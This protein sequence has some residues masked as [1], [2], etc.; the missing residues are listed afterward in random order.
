MTFPSSMNLF[1]PLGFAVALSIVCSTG[2]PLWA[3]AP[4]TSTEQLGAVSLPVPVLTRDA[5]GLVTI[6]GATA[7]QVVCYTLDGTDPISRSGPYLAPVDLS[8]GGKIKARIF[9]KDRKQSGEIAAESYEPIVGL[10]PISNSLVPVTQDRSW[11]SYDWAKRHAEVSAA[12]QRQHP[13]VI[14]IGDSITHFFGGNAVWKQNYEP[15]N[16]VNLGFGW[17]RTE[18][19]LWRLEHGELDGASPKV[20]VVMIGTNNLEKNKDEEIAD[21]IKAICEEIHRR[22]PTTKILLLGIFPRGQKPGGSRDR[23]AH[24]NETIAAL[25]QHDGVTFLDF[26]AKF[27]NPDGTIEKSIMGD[28]LHPSPAGYQIWVEAMA[29]TLAK[30]L[31]TPAGH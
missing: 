2:H 3:Q 16:S 28:F 14:F 27:L 13:E 18:N 12:V 6:G 7:D 21:G 22:L 8:H 29:P 19:V 26:G 10:K 24:I 20:A 31:G 25:D 15:L 4:A 30:L 9:T 5:A 17:D 1:R 23:I 11:P